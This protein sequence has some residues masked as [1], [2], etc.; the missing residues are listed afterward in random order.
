MNPG[1]MPPKQIWLFKLGCWLTLATATMY[2]AA[3]FFGL[4]TPANDTERHLQDL[5]TNYHFALPG[6]A[7]RSLMDL[8]DG[9]SLSYAALLVGL[10]AVGLVVSRRASGDTPLMLGVARSTALTCVA[11]MIVS[12]MNFFIVP[13]I[14]L[15]ALV[16][17][18][19]LASVRP[20]E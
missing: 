11:L 16:T 12:L 18:F 2:V 19:G 6:K 20:P 1:E 4:G 5:S 7:S 3:V 14:F 17:C 8:F 10:A 15:A 9:L 13:T